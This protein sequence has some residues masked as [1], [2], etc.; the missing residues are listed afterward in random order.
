MQRQ[1][2]AVVAIA[3]AQATGISAQS[4]NPLN[5]FISLAG[6]AAT[7]VQSAEAA[8]TTAASTSSTPSSASSTAASTSAAAAATSSAAAAAAT[9]GLSTQTKLDIIIPVV[10]IGV[11]ALLLLALCIFCCLRKRRRSR[12]VQTPVRDEE[13]TNWRR[14]NNPGRVYDGVD[15]RGQV[16]MSQQPTV[17]LMTAAGPSSNR[18]YTADHPAYRHEN[19]FVPVPPSPRRTAPNSRAGLTDG[20]VVGAPAYVDSANSN[21]RLH[22]SRSMSRSTS[23][24]GL[25]DGYNNNKNNGN[26]LGYDDIPLVGAGVGAGALGVGSGLNDPYDKFS[27]RPNNNGNYYNQHGEIAVPILDHN[28]HS[29]TGNYPNSPDD[30]NRT[31]KPELAPLNTDRNRPPTPFGL[32]ALGSNP[33]HNQPQ[34]EST[35]EPMVSPESPQSPYHR[36]GSPYNDMHVHHLQTGRPSSDLTRIDQAY[37]APIQPAAYTSLPSSRPRDSTR[38]SGYATPPT[39]PSRSPNR[40]SQYHDST[41][42]SHNSQDSHTGSGSGSVESWATTNQIPQPLPP[43]APWEDRERR[44]SNGS[45]GR[46]Y[47]GSPRQSLNGNGNGSGTPTSVSGHGKRLRFSDVQQDLEPDWNHRY[48]QGVGEAM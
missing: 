24:V 29:Q 20:M 10:V 8:Q 19:P 47:S 39:V 2:Y 25:N 1:L 28:R 3:I 14:P 12:R 21:Q 23:G 9:G 38:R 17:P 45:P 7:A 22:K 6:S 32:S 46:K 30:Y 16:P 13:V 41:Y 15:S 33:H 27:G 26:G 42:D 43:S 36:I 37:P 18:P 11:L 34:R 31:N 35:G 5:V 40:R 4:T 48:S 44:Y